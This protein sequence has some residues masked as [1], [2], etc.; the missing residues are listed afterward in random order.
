MTRLALMLFH[1]KTFSFQ[2]ITQ[3]SHQEVHNR[4]NNLMRHRAQYIVIDKSV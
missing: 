3:L 2:L 4:T 1:F